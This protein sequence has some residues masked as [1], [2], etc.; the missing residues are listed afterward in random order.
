MFIIW[1]FYFQ[2][3]GTL[4]L[5]IISSLLALTASGYFCWELTKRVHDYDV[6]Q[7]TSRDYSPCE[8]AVSQHQVCEMTK[9]ICHLMLFRISVISTLV[10]L[11]V[12]IVVLVFLSERI[13]FKS[14]IFIL[15]SS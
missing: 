10:L 5:N 3:K 9:H 8:S 6:C 14:Y 12:C 2:I 13:D 11:Y 4:A 1:V 7:E 15:V